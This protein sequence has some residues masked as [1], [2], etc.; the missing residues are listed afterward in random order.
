MSLC[1]HTCTP[2]NPC[3]TLQLLTTCYESRSLS[4]KH[5]SLQSLPKPLWSHE[6]PKTLSSQ[7][8]HCSRFWNT[9]SAVAA[10]GPAFKPGS[11]DR[12]VIFF[13]CCGRKNVLCV[14]LLRVLSQFKFSPSS[15]R[16]LSQ[17]CCTG[18]SSQD[19]SPKCSRNCSFLFGWRGSGI[20]S[21]Q[22]AWWHS[23]SRSYLNTSHLA[24]FQRQPIWPCF[25]FQFLSSQA[26][27]LPP[28]PSGQKGKLATE[29]GFWGHTARKSL[30]A[31][32]M[33]IFSWVL[34]S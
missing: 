4:W 20:N 17:A 21:Q 31:F 14:F 13:H 29:V 34:F 3:F 24:N 5:P 12:A 27:C 33:L 28:S 15:T 8:S 25:H 10:R 11:G 7:P 6:M 30:S 9:C 23:F 1:S 2:T 22:N 19:M 26:R 16:F 18:S 32:I